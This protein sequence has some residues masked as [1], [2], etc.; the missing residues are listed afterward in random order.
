MYQNISKTTRL[1]IH[2]LILLILFNSC[3]EETS[4]QP[5]Q[6]LEKDEIGWINSIDYITDSL[7]GNPF[8]AIKAFDSISNLFSETDYPFAHANLIYRRSIF[9]NIEGN[10]SESYRDLAEV[11]QKI[12]N[13][14]KYLSALCIIEM[15]KSQVCLLNYQAVDTLLALANELSLEIEATGNLAVIYNISANIASNRGNYL[16]SSELYLKAASIYEAEKDTARLAVIYQNLGLLYSDADNYEFAFMYIRKTIEFNILTKDTWNQA[17]NINNLGVFHKEINQPDSAL[18]YYKESLALF[19]DLKSLRGQAMNYMNIG[20]VYTLKDNFDLAHS[21]Y[22][23][24]LIIINEMNSEYGFV[25]EQIN[26]ADIYLRQGNFERAISMLESSLS[27]CRKMDLVSEETETLELLYR[28]WES[29]G[30]YKKALGYFQQYQSIIDSIKSTD[31]Q[32]KLILLK[33]DYE[34]KNKE[35]EI[36]KMGKTLEQAA[37]EAKKQIF[38]TSAGLLLIVLLSIILYYRKRSLDMEVKLVKQKLALAVIRFE[39]KNQEYIKVSNQLKEQKETT[40]QDILLTD[41]TNH[42]DSNSSSSWQEFLTANSEDENPIDQE[43][44]ENRFHT[45]NE[46]FFKRLLQRHPDLTPAEIRLCGYL[47]LNMTSKEI[48]LLINR[49]LRTVE[50]TRNNIR[51]KIALPNK[52]NLISYLMKI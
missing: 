51:Q 5:F 12:R 21:Y 13:R 43:G 44:Y 15:A 10:C 41:E 28:S 3:Q 47:K 50:N 14:S 6:S 24:S 7:Y 46:L 45:A 42:I 33:N 30:N 38:L 8:N 11:L 36:L 22:D 4:N 27:K 23:S 49:S 18:F 16:K 40:E 31:V 20:N 37:L 19:K 48:A 17:T 29:M 39:E 35:V 52:T 34:L 25:L 32:N 2:A 1:F 26:R 9:N